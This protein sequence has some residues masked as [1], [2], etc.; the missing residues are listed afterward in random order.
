MARR[1]RYRKKKNQLVT[2][3]PLD[4]ETSGLRFRKW[5]SRQHAKAGDW[6]VQSRVDGKPE[7][8][9]VDKV[10]FARTYRRVSEGR[11]WKKSPVW[12]ERADEAGTI[13]TKEGVTRFRRGDYIVYNE[14]SGADGYAVTARIFEAL[15]DRF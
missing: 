2:A 6:L 7:V 1:L 10:S 5:G 12:A 8:Y 3:V 9:S 13:R 11:Y 15:Y 4:L 14:R